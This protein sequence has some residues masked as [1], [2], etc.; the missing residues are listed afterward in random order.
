[1]FEIGVDDGFVSQFCMEGLEAVQ[2][3]A[4]ATVVTSRLGWIAQHGGK[5]VGPA[6]EAVRLWHRGSALRFER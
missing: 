3:L 6:D 1:L 5:T 2:I 4:G